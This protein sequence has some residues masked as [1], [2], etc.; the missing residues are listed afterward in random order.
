MRFKWV[1]LRRAD[2]LKI[3][4]TMRPLKGTDWPGSVRFV[5]QGTLAAFLNPCRLSA[6]RVWSPARLETSIYAPS[7]CATRLWRAAPKTARVRA[8]RG[9]TP[10][11]RRRCTSIQTTQPK[12]PSQCDHSPLIPMR[13]LKSKLLLKKIWTFK[14]IGILIKMNDFIK[15]CWIN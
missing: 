3:M 12:P 2:F 7:S 10:G 8:P 13:F 4:H 9:T 15:C 6:V 14:D 5:L 1:Q 11:A